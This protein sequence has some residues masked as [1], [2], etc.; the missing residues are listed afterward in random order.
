[1]QIEWK[2][3]RTISFIEA[4]VEHIDNGIRSSRRLAK[5]CVRNIDFRKAATRL[6]Y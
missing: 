6:N 3:D 1:M 4:F 2:Q 5:E